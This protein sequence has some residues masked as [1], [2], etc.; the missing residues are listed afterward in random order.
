M[1]WYKKISQ[2]TLVEDEEKQNNTVNKDRDIKFNPKMISLKKQISSKPVIIVFNNINPNEKI[3]IKNNKDIII[4]EL[5][6]FNK[7]IV[8]KNLNS[9]DQLFKEIY[10][11]GVF[12]NNWSWEQ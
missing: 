10:P 9:I 12:T 5:H 4:F 3:V 6:H 7:P 11:L 2:M 1:N 8:A